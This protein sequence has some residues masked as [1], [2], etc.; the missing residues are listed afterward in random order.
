MYENV[1]VGERKRS[2]RIANR[3]MRVRYLYSVVYHPFSFF[4]SSFFSVYPPVPFCVSTQSRLYNTRM[5]DVY[6]CFIIKCTTMV[7]CYCGG[8]DLR[9]VACFQSNFLILNHKFSGPGRPEFYEFYDMW[10]TLRDFLYK[11][12]KQ[13]S[14][15]LCRVTV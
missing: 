8:G 15:F 1:W 6:S 10:L 4:F 13:N 11:N 3:S 12:G 7:G 9:I 14:L 2:K 5:P